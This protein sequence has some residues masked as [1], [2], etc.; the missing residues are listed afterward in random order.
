MIYEHPAS[1]PS[2]SES[3]IQRGREWAGPTLR[4]KLLKLCVEELQVWLAEVD[5]W[6]TIL[7]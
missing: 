7:A 2:R 1:H 3:V 6:Q 4:L 5:L